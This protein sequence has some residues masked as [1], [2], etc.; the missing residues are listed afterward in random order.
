MKNKTIVKCLPIALCVFLSCTLS[1]ATYART[2]EILGNGDIV[3]EL[4]HGT[5]QNGES[6]GDVG[7]RYDM[8]VYEM[9]EANPGLDPWVPKPGSRV[10]IPAK[11]I[12]PAGP[13]NGLV[14]NL[15][16][17]RL[18]Y[19][20][21][22]KRYVTTFPIGIGKK[23]WS[24]PLGYSTVIGKTKDPS[25]TPPASIRAEHRRKG[26]ILPAVVPAG[27]ENP[28]GRYA[29]KLGFEGFLIHGS[30][31]PG[32]IGVRSSHGCVRLFNEDIEALFHLVPVGTSIRIV[33]EPLKVGWQNGHLYLEAHESLSDAKYNGCNS[34][35]VLTRL[36]QG[37]A[38]NAQYVDWKSVIHAARTPNGYPVRID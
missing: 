30:H 2:F 19:Y 3:G 15:A 29:L 26:D 12:L 1:T 33:H 20:H 37:A 9:L 32:G 4:E 11:F 25:W 36:I 34:S 21:P 13:R 27:P 35:S 8:G 17:M 18:Y 23:G 31:R 6:L 24:S 38:Q 5:V 16:E 14:L 10:V 7:R 28:L 22:N